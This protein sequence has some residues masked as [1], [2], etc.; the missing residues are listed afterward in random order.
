MRSKGFTLVELMIVVAIIGV[1]AV[2]GMSTFKHYGDTG[3]AAEAMSMIAEFKSKEEAYKAEYNTYTSTDTAE[4]NLTPSLSSNCP[5]GQVEPCPKS[6]AKPWS[7]GTLANW[8]TLGVN[9]TR[10]QLYCGYVVIAGAAN[11]WN[12][13]TPTAAAS[14]AGSDGQ[15]LF[16][17]TAPATPWFYVRAQCDNNPKLSNNTTYLA[18]SNAAT[19]VTLNDH[20]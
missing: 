13:T 5:S 8:A 10:S 6:V 15:K 20:Q 17:N 14:A 4:T 7:S 11:S 16:S 18:S 1:L 12:G 3:R 19:V 2:V 9:T